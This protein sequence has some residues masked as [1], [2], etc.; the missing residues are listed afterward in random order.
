MVER[1]VPTESIKNVTSS[2]IFTI[3]AK[4]ATG[5]GIWDAQLDRICDSASRSPAQIRIL[6]TFLQGGIRLALET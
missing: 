3:P 4:G 6:L 1:N 2:L 5:L